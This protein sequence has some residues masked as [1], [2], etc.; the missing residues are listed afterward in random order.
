[1]MAAPRRFGGGTLVIATHNEG[2]RREIA[3]LLEARAATVLSAAGLGLP[4][5]EEDPQGSYAGNAAIKAL[6]AAR[7]SGHPAL[8]DDSGFEVAALGGWPGVNSRPEA[9][10]LGGFVPAME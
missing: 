10:A 9:D 5:P 8:A 3:A 7:A 6:A 1:E 4:E 2:K